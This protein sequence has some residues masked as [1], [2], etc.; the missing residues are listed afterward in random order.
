MGKSLKIKKKKSIQVFRL[1]TRKMKV[2]F[3]KY[4]TDMTVYLH[5]NHSNKDIYKHH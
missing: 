1:K 5:S 3:T 2:F 4:N